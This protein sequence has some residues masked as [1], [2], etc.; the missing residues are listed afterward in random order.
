MNRKTI[1][2]VLT[3]LALAAGCA[4]TPRYGATRYGEDPYGNTAYSEPARQPVAYRGRI[5]SI[6]TIEVDPGYRFGVGSVIGA[7]AGGLLG[8][9]I[10]EGSGST[11]AAIAGAAIGGA[12]GTAVERRQNTQLAS[13]VTV[14]LRD[15]GKVTIVQPP[16]PQLRPG[17]RVSIVGTG[18]NA[19]VV[20]MGAS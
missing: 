3:A 18:E 15:G 6:E 13:R 8:S 16:D 1:P 17:Q 12:A 9:Q 19:R 2:I 11:A 20:P 14:D 10:G 4:E 7:V 5:D